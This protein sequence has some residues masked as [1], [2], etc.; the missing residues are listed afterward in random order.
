MPDPSV[1]LP[2]PHRNAF[3]LSR[4]R[5]PRTIGLSDKPL[6]PGARD[7]LRVH[8]CFRRD[9]LSFRRVGA[10]EFLVHLGA[11]ARRL[12][13]YEIA[14]FDDRRHGDHVVLPGHI[15]DVDLRDRNWDRGAHKPPG[16]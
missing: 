4:S 1:R 9:F 6:L 10:N 16:L 7:V 15:V 11:L 13:Q 12:R 5:Q 14:D 2:A 3:R 8:R